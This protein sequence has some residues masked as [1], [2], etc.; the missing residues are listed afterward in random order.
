MLYSEMSKEELRRE[1][2]ELQRKG[3]EA[4]ERENWSEYEIYMTRWYLA[5]SYEI[6]DDVHIEIGR[7]Y[8][9]AEEYDRLTVTAIEGVMAWG[10]RQMTGETA[11][12]P[13]AQL[14]EADE[15]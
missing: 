11:A 8:R 2:A 7:T 4:Y 5:K 3:R 14:E 10:I 15:A 9:I 13:I 12:V 6:K 1:M